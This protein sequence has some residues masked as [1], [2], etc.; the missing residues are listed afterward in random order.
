MSDGLKM[1]ALIKQAPYASS[2]T[3]VNPYGAVD[4]AHAKKIINPFDK[5]T[6]QK[7]I[8]GVYFK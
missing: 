7:P 4:R 6:L 1:A 2:A 5:F 8:T 3:G